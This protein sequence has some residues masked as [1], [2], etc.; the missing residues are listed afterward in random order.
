MSVKG[1]IVVI[2]DEVNAAAALETLLREDGYDVARAH[3]ARTGM[4][5]LE[6]HEPDVVH[7]HDWHAR[8]LSAEP[9]CRNG[10]APRQVSARAERRFG[11]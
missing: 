2:D 7:G 11:D 10:R 3:D 8:H 4:Q 1:R 6:K 5:L 9:R